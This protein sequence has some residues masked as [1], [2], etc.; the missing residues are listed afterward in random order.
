MAVD[1]VDR[2]Q[3]QPLERP[4][5]ADIAVAVRDALSFA[6][7]RASDS[8]R[9]ENA[10][11]GTPKLI[12]EMGKDFGR[13]LARVA[14]LKEFSSHADVVPERDVLPEDSQRELVIDENLL[15]GQA[16]ILLSGPG[17]GLA[18]GSAKGYVLNALGL[19]GAGGAGGL[20]DF[21]RGHWD[22]DYST[23]TKWVPVKD[24]LGL[25]VQVRADGATNQEQA[26]NWNNTNQTLWLKIPRSTPV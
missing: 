14:E 11:S 5:Q 20:R 9:N 19:T 4:R 10:P 13:L 2:P 22:G 23:F 3:P 6:R 16:L 18:G 12:D 21:M 15:P 25:E 7:T 8:V 24:V 17:G 1:H 26:T